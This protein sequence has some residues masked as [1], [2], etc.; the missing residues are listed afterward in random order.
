MEYL[1]HYVYNSSSVAPYVTFRAIVKD[2]T[3]MSFLAS[4]TN[5]LRYLIRPFGFAQGDIIP[6]ILSSSCNQRIFS[7]WHN[8]IL[9]LRLRC[10]QNDNKGNTSFRMTNSVSLSVSE[11]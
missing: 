8:K 9:L 10:V 5:L 3:L 1:V 4:A 6:I 7:C 11:E 2:H